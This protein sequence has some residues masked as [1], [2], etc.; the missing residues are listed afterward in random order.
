VR[1]PPSHPSPLRG[2]YLVRN[3]PWNAYLHA[4][5]R[6]LALLAR[7]ESA[8]PLAPPRRILLAVG[9]HLGDAII[10]ASAVA[11]ARRAFPEAEIG[12]L[13]GSWARAGVEGHPDVRW[14]HT[15]D[16][17]KMNRSAASLTAKWIHD[18][19]SRREALREIRAVGYDAAVDLYVYYPNVAPLL[20]RAG[21]PIRIGYTRGGH[22]SLDTHPVDWADGDRHASEDHAALLRVLSPD[23]ADVETPPYEVPPIPD[24]ARQCAEA[25]LREEGVRVGEYVVMHMTAGAPLREWPREKWRQLAEHLTAEGHQL[26]FTGSGA[27]QERAAADVAR[28]L[29]G[30]VNLCGR[31]GWHEFIH[32]IARAQ[33]VVSVET[34]AAHIAAAVGTP[35][36]ALWTGV[37]RLTHWRPLGP[38]ST[39]LVNPVPCAPCFRGS[40]CAAMSC[41]R[42]V[43]VDEV[44][45]AVHGRVEGGG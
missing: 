30:S 44:L 17:W 8:K 6:L 31:L 16:Q 33:L 19:R 37:T 32:V 27:A 2:R 3:R 18:R 39:V 7:S 35:C 26:V 43:S 22:G 13:V 34:V 10:A 36:V 24:A 20:W 42:D 5:D 40:G 12:M 29:A 4:A 9:G 41:V 14:I 25:T 15:V 28:G 23:L 1:G 11:L 38:R 21:I 45:K